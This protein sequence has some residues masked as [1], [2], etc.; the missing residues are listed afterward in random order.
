MVEKKIEGV[1][2]G[3]LLKKYFKVLVSAKNYSDTFDKR[4]QICSYLVVSESG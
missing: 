4:L 2:C 3:K 1:K